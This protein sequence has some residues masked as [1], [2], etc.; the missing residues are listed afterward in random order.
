MN[1][2]KKIVDFYINA[3]L[4]VALSV[5]AMVQITL[6]EFEQSHDV[7]L[8]GALF[9]GTIVAYNFIK[10]GT[11]AKKFYIVET[12]YVKMIQLL[13]F[14]CAAFAAYCFLQLSWETIIWSGALCML[15]VIYALPIS[16][17]HR[18]IRNI[19]G[20][21]VH[22]VAIVW[23]GATVILPLVNA[24]I[25]LNTDVLIEVIQR[26]LFVLAIM[27]PFEIRDLQFDAPSLGTIPQI[28]GVKKTKGLGV[29]CLLAM[30]LLEIFNQQHEVK[31]FLIMLFVAL[32]SMG[33]IINAS[34]KKNKYYCGFWVE[35]IPILWAVLLFLF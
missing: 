32:L 27:M 34:V 1:V 28:F 23:S 19:H 6:F 35:S 9:F 10:F 33:M 7:L 13:S 31:H 12:R 21:K 2:F 4:I 30:M 18:N 20:I 15:N 5:A 3:S 25:T 14:A 29:F 8:T 24:K 22:I 16:S 11:Q 26:Y 17:N